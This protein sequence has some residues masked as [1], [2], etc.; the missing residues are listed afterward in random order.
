MR[1]PTLSTF[2]LLAVLSSVA[3]VAAA[4]A[5]AATTS[6]SDAAL[7]TVAEQSKFVRTGRYDEVQRLCEAYAQKWPDVVK[8]VNFG[9]TPEG[10]PM[11]ALVASRSGALTP[12]EARRRGLPV[13]LMQGGIHAG[14]V[15]GKD[16][17][18]LALRELL[19]DANALRNF[20][21]VFVPVFNV[22]G[23]ERFGRWNRPNQVGPEEMGWRTTAQNLNLNR[24]YMKAD[25]PEMHAMLGLLNAWDP[26]LYVDM[27]VTDGA[28]FQHDVSNTV[29]PLYSG[30]AA[31]HPAAKALV[32]ELNSKIAAMGSHPLDF[33]PEFVKEDDPD[34]GFALN[35]YSPRFSTAY[36]GLHNRFALLVETHSWKDYATRVRVTHNII[37]TLADMMSREGAGWRAQA[38]AADARAQHLGGQTVTLDFDNGPHVT[39]IDFLGYA[40]T[41]K[42][43]D[44][45]GAVATYYD[46]TKPTVWHV[47]LRDTIVPQTT[48]QAPRGGYIVTAAD[49][50]WMAAKLALHGIT[51]TKLPREIASAA[52]QAFRAT[53][54]SYSKETF[55]GHTMLTFQGTWAPEKRTIPAGSLFVPMAQRNSRLVVALLEPRGVDSLAAW[56]FFD[57]AFERKEYMEPYVEEQVAVEML[58]HDPK[59]AADFKKRLA[60]DRQFAAD[61][62]ARLEYFYRLSP[63]WDERFNLYPVYRVEGALPRSLSGQ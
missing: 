47:P 35:V 9:R 52:V 38:M 19:Q 31:L 27:H 45:S 8:C 13:M 29:D 49:A 23:H 63:S 7:E 21:L 16:A 46:A 15:D 34:S 48:V 40:Y 26:V 56:G 20:V 43:S 30:D 51:F 41:R 57:G 32:T 53:Q 18:F 44:I 3:C 4:P 24:D 61:P 33:Y 36:W 58:A 59:V 25:T 22:D 2:V 12:E 17:G 62:D 10:R 14:E 37:M 42:H 39:T 1:I 60:E 54:V 50:D 11:L 5:R 28:N 6:A 55:E